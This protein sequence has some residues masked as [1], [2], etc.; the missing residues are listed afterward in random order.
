MAFFIILGI[1][2]GSFGTSATLPLCTDKIT[3]NCVSQHV[4]DTEDIGAGGG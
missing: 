4:N 2:L 1:V 3:H